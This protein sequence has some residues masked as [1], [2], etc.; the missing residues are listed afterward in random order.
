MTIAIYKLAYIINESPSSLQIFGSNKP[1]VRQ[2]EKEY[3]KVQLSLTDNQVTNS[4]SH[5]RTV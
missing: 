1:S 5:S 3:Y 2:V 4:L